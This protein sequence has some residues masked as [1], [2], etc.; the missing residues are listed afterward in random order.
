MRH[1]AL[2]LLGAMEPP[3][4]AGLDAGLVSFIENPK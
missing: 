4:R 1:T 3:V 2:L